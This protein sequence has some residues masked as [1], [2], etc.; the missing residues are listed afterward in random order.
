MATSSS[1]RFSVSADLNVSGP[2]QYMTERFPAF[3]Q[4]LY[5]GRSV[6][7]NYAVKYRGQDMAS[8]LAIAVETDYASWHGTKELLEF[9]R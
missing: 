4:E 8:A 9:A 6:V 5:A 3:K 7:F 2:A 1:S